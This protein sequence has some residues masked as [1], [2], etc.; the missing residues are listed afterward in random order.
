MTNTVR[1]FP[2]IALMLLMD[3]QPPSR[4]RLQ[5]TSRSGA[6][7]DLFKFNLPLHPY[8]TGSLSPRRSLM[9]ESVRTTARFNSPP[10]ISGTPILTGLLGTPWAGRMDTG[11]V[12]KGPHPQFSFLRWG[13]RRRNRNP[14]VP[15]RRPRAAFALPD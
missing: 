4:H 9:E 11:T 12:S 8:R 10:S 5:L 1:L 6:P 7:L 15:R 13:C 3:A 14:G 2:A